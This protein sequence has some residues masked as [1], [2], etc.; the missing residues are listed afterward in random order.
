MLEPETGPSFA[1]AERKLARSVV[2]V[3]ALASIVAIVGPILSYRSDTAELRRV[4]ESRVERD[5]FSSAEALSR[6]LQ[7]LQNEL[8]RLANRPEINLLD[9]SLQPERELLN[10]AHRQS[11]LFDVGV[12]IVGPDG[13]MVWS[14]PTELRKQSLDRRPWFHRLASSLRPTVDVAFPENHTFLMAVPI[15]R[16]GGLSGALVGLFRPNHRTLPLAP[17]SP[18]FER[19]VVDESGDVLLPEAPPEWATRP[20]FL[21]NV[22]ALLQQPEG[23]TMQF[24][25]ESRFIVADSVGTT[26]LRLLMLAN[27]EAVTRPLR[28]RFLIQ[29]FFIATLQMGAVVTLSLFTR[30]IYTRFVAMERRALEQERLVALG[31]AAGLIAHEVKNSLNGLK[32]ALSFLSGEVKDPLPLKTMRGEVDRLQHLS[33]SLLQFGRPLAA[34]RQR[35]SLGEM[36][37]ET[38]DALR[39]LPEFDE[40]ELVVTASEP[41]DVECDPLLV[42]TALHNLIRNA[43]EATV[44]AKDLGVIAKPQ[45]WI[46]AG[47]TGAEAVVEVDD[48]A[49]GPNPEVEGQLF[50]PFVSGKAKGIGLGLAMS[51]R[52][53]EEQGGTIAFERIAAGSRF[54]VRL[55]LTPAPSA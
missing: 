16:D 47:Q 4:F 2:A 30:R 28:R 48:N 34:Q 17:T 33:T 3:F 44:T 31:T 49:G 32:A 14:E 5:A 18:A 10:L 36:V 50:E 27:E 20:E 55:P 6:H 51:K 8:E 21:K 23:T 22:E 24:G 54:S 52:A 26:G 39:A 42:T 13:R 53:M 37:R 29:L 35:V 40:A 15:L 41:I 43:I 7:L 46:R 11:A 12:A 38:V 25:S 19:L 45:V 9:Q 1:E